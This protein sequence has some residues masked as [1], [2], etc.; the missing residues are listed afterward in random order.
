LFKE[1]E[2]GCFVE[3]LFRLPP[4]GVKQHIAGRLKPPRKD[5]GAAGKKSPE[6]SEES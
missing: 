4:K 3:K 1:F 5:D 6:G 2:F